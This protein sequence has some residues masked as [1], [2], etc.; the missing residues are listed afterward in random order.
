MICFDSDFIMCMTTRSHKQ[1][2][3]A[4]HWVEIIHCHCH[5]HCQNSC[6]LPLGTVKETLQEY[7]SEVSGKAD[8]HSYSRL[9]LD[10]LRLCH[11][12][13]CGKRLCYLGEKLISPSC[14]DFGSEMR[15]CVL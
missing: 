6:V 15:M 7:R 14:S 2:L 11:K 9:L 4:I 5:C 13:D 8:R 10:K 3:C 1:A 12:V